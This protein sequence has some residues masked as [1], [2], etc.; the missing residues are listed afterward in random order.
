MRMILLSL[1]MLM[2][3]TSVAMAAPSLA[4]QEGSWICL[5]DDPIAPQVLV[6]FEEN[7]YRR[8][9][10]N[11]CSLYDILG[12][13]RHRNTTEVSFAPGASMRADDDGS[14]YT[15]TLVLGNAMITSSGECT[16]RGKEPEPDAFEKGEPR[17]GG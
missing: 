1:A 7:I 4:A 13:R 12:V 9:D 15:E 2:V 8:C 16:F 3:A 5:S 14:R 11:T 10:Q 6:D 17:R